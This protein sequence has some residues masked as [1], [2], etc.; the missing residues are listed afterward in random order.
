VLTA[1][2]PA[3]TNALRG[4]LP[5]NAL[6]QLTQ[7]L[8][9]CNQDLTHRGNVVI[10]PDGW[11]NRANNN[12]VFDSL[13]PTSREYNEYVTPY[14]PGDVIDSPYNNSYNTN[15]DYGDVITVLGGPP[16]ADGSAGRAGVD[17][18]AGVNGLDGR[19]GS[20][21]SDG[22]PGSPGAAGT[23]GGDGA[24]GPPG[25]PG[26]AG[27]AGRDGRDGAAGRDG[28]DG[29]VNIDAITGTILS[30]ILRRLKEK[31]GIYS[32]DEVLGEA[33]KV[34]T[35]KKELVVGVDCVDGELVVD[36]LPFRVVEFV[37]PVKVVTKVKHTSAIYY[38][39]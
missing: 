21:G 8:G 1:A 19:D 7:A 28:R 34:S 23:A 3:V 25:F 32:V 14:L 31:P 38:G 36:K 2:M 9:N 11:L 37:E 22:A 5:P 16:G 17:G 20:D 33:S 27:A 18:V 35:S 26:A 6:K 12:G 30:A 24:A 13:P 29:N 4:V 15:I 39:P 10:Q